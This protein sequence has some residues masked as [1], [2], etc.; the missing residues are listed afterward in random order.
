MPNLTFQHLAVCLPAHNEADS[1]ST[2]LPELDDALGLIRLKQVTVFVF[3]D[4]SQDGTAD[5]VRSANLSNAEV[6]L[7]QSLARVGKSS[8][9][10]RCVS[11]ALKAGADAV[12]MM[13]ADGQDNPA[14]IPDMLLHLNSGFDVVNGRRR[15]RAHGFGKRI[16][17]RAFNSMV[18]LVTRQKFLDVNSG[19][20]AFSQRGAESLGPYFYGELH[21][22]I[23]IIAVWIGLSVG[24]EPVMNRPRFAGRTKYGFARGW[25]GLS[26]L[27]TIQFLRRY[28]NSPGHFF[29]WFGGFLIFLGTLL[30]GLGFDGSE[31][32]G[33]FDFLPWSG[34]T[35]GGFGLMLVSFGFLSELMLFLAKA[36][37]TSVT[38]VTRVGSRSPKP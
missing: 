29:S 1:L 19:L 7:I 9:L 3:D 18:R 38:T 17:S 22:V 14:Y 24:E 28:H 2:L 8:G 31:A 20:K 13:D 10:Q 32:G 37:V 25:R 26:D 35:I 34:V 11:L 23:L 5:V 16:S 30:F 12:V 6:F 21:R 27:L 4:G 36:P 15:N 33:V